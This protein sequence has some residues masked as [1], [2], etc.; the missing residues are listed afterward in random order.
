M[1]ENPSTTTLGNYDLLAD[2]GQQGI[3]LSPA[4]P[5]EGLKISGQRPRSQFVRAAEKPAAA[6][7]PAAYNDQ[8][9]LGQLLINILMMITGALDPNN[10]GNNGLMSMLSKAFGFEDDGDHK[11][12]REL[13]G[14]I[15]SR[16]REAARND[17]DYSRFDRNAAIAAA[18]EGQPLIAKNAYQSQMLEL[19][20]KHESGGDYNRVFAHKGVKR[21][22]VENMTLNEVVAWQKAYV[23][24]QKAQGYSEN[25]RSGAIG[26]YQV[27]T[28]TLIAS[29]KEL[30]L[31]GDEKMDKAM[32]DRIGAHLLE[33]RGYSAYL[34]GRMSESKFL[35]GLSSEWASLPKDASGVGVHDGVGTNRAAKN[36]YGAVLAAAKTDQSKS[37]SDDFASVRAGPPAPSATNNPI[38]VAGNA[39]T[40]DSFTPRR[41]Q[42][43]VAAPSA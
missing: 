29:M 4:T 27:I 20:G 15:K 17:V 28:P 11:K 24:E 5:G 1:T 2:R 8:N 25:N 37:L 22:D 10:K 30:G 3:A 40:P 9:M 41:P 34:D 12:I 16:G 6:A 7:N 43:S 23:N 38:V 18:R 39:P 31:K 26:K 35:K 32:Q 42:T 13:N 19:I 14:D 33:K 21:I 36:T